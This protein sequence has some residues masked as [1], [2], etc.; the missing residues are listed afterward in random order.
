LIMIPSLN[1]VLTG[2]EMLSLLVGALAHDVGHEGGL[3]VCLVCSLVCDLV[4]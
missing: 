1:D 4:L 3:G 2:L